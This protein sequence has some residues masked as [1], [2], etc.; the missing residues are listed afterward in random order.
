MGEIDDLSMQMR[1]D[2]ERWFPRIHDRNLADMPLPVFY[3]LGL[4]GETGEALDQVK[5]LYRDGDGA[6]LTAELADVMTYL[7]LP[8]D[9]VGI[10]LVASYHAKTIVNEERF[11]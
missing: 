3:A 8:A 4:G 6:G 9:E 1:S 7:F 11:G 2:S 10:D 5:K